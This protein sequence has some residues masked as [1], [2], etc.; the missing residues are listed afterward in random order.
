MKQHQFQRVLLHVR[1]ELDRFNSSLAKL[2]SFEFPSS[3][4]LKLIGEQQDKSGKAILALDQIEADFIDDPLGAS[5]RLVSEFRKVVA[6]RRFLE[7]LE[8]ARSDEVPWSLIPSIESLAQKLLPAFDILITTTPDMNYMV[9]W[10]SDLAIIYL[11]KLHR[12]NGFLHVLV[13]HELFHPIV[14]E[15]FVSERPKCVPKLRELCQSYLSRKGTPTDLF[16]QQR[17]DALL[18]HA[19]SQWEKALTELMCDMGAVAIFGPAAL[20]SLSGFAA[21]QEMNSAPSHL[22]QYYPPWQMRLRVANDFLARFGNVSARMSEL[23]VQ[24]RQ[25]DLLEHSKLLESS[26][27]QETVAFTTAD[28]ALDPMREL[29]VPVYDLVESCLFDAFG[30]IESKSCQFAK[31]WTETLSEIPSLLTRLS[32]NVPPSEII[33]SQK[34]ESR[35]ASMTAIVMACWIERLRLESSSSL[36]LNSF[37]RLCRLM[38]K[39]IE[40]AELKRNYLDWAA[41]Q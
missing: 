25:A 39:A 9:G 23:A 1:F 30:F 3:I 24:L 26:I 6:R 16:F 38:L 34:H 10:N 13:G 37:R 28:L 15:F 20:W 11:P 35:A 36:V 17:L 32:L 4:A 19:T 22:N 29:S 5:A 27:A 2:E 33:E 31:R 8:K 21:T 18:E 7:V 40:D 12:A 14:T 41:K